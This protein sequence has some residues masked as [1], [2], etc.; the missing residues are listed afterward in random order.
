MK[1]FNYDNIIEQCK[2]FP[3][4]K[5]MVLYKDV[6]EIKQV[7]DYLIQ[8]LKL[9]VTHRP[10]NCGWEFT[11]YNNSILEIDKAGMSLRGKKCHY[12]WIDDCVDKEI[13]DN[14]I[15]PMIIPYNEAQA[16]MGT[17]FKNWNKF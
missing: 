6:F 14:I 4:Y 1:E 3:N 15:I 9:D 17:M 16:R 12:A 13:I 11:F 5:V 2:T 7:I 8:T 10:T